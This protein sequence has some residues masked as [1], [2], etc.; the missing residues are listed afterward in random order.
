MNKDNKLKRLH[1]TASTS[2][3]L[4]DSGIENNVCLFSIKLEKENF[5]YV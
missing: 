4:A 1:N 2:Y 5:T 3:R